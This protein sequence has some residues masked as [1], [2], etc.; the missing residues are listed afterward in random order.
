LNRHAREGAA[1]FGAAVI[2]YA[3]GEGTTRV[4]AASA[5]GAT[6]PEAFGERI[7]RKTKRLAAEQHRRT[8][9]RRPG[10]PE[11]RPGLTPRT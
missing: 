10:P 8:A 6:D 5:A 3:R 1:R 2:A 11:I 4:E 9:Q 7:R